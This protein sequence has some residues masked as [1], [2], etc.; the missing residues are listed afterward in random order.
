[1]WLFGE[2]RHI[3]KFLISVFWQAMNARK[4]GRVIQLNIKIIFWL[5]Q[6]IQNKQNSRISHDSS[7]SYKLKYPSQLQFP[8][9]SCSGPK[10]FNTWYIHL[11]WS[12][13]EYIVFK[14]H[15]KFII[16]RIWGLAGPYLELTW[17]HLYCFQIMQKILA[18]WSCFVWVLKIFVVLPGWPK[19]AKYQMILH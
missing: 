19:P 4:H 10:H 13:K 6:S 9:S 12:I 18:F 2:I 15:S 17:T 8:D 11:E 14:S 3:C 5:H 1:M 16:T 7:K